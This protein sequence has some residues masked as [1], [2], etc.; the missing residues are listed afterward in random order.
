MIGLSGFELVIFSFVYGLFRNNCHYGNLWSNGHVRRTLRR[1]CFGIWGN[2]LRRCVYIAELCRIGFYFTSFGYCM[3]IKIGSKVCI[4]S[5]FL[6]LH[7]F[8][9]YCLFVLVLLSQL[10]VNRLPFF[11][12]FNPMVVVIIRTIFNLDKCQVLA[13]F[14]N[15]KTVPHLPHLCSVSLLHNSAPLMLHWSSLSFL[16]VLI[17]QL[18]GL[19]DHYFTNLTHLVSAHFFTQN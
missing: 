16:L 11:C 5:Q 15:V 2:G 9:P 8:Y 6:G 1:A 3:T 10:W 18:W 4:L 12:Y 19:L 17:Q 13:L 7:R 14:S